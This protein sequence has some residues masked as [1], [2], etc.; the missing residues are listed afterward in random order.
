[1][2]DKHHVH[3]DCGK[4]QLALTGLPKVH[5]FCHCEDCRELLQVPYHSVLAWEP[6]FVEFTQGEQEIRVFQHPTKRMTRV[7]CG[8]CGDVL[9]NTNAMGWKLVSQ[10]MFT[11]CNGNKL[12]Q[13]FESSSHFF[14]DRRI[15][16]I[17]D[18]LPK[19]G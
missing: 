11:K 7:F 5:G 16:D 17:D 2:T 9:Y 18:E 14:Y 15:V 1:M 3:C 8:H 12:P 6:E 19:R 4:V 10:L 13:G